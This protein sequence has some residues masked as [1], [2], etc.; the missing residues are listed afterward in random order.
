MYQL[1]SNDDQ[2]DE[3]IAD[4]GSDI[5]GVGLDTETYGKERIDRLFSLQLS[6]SRN[7]WYFN[8]HDYGGVPVLDK[9]RTFSALSGTLGNSNALWFIHN[10]KF[11]MWKLLLENIR[12]SG[13]VHCTQS[14]E[15]FIYN[16]YI[17][18]SL[19]ACL[20]RRGRQKND[21]VAAYID[22]HKLWTGTGDAKRKHF[23]KVPFPTM[24]R[25]ACIDAEEVRWLG[26]DQRRELAIRHEGTLPDYYLNDLEMQKV[27]FEMEVT[28]MHVRTDYA[29]GGLLYEKEQ[30]Q[31]TANT[32]SDLAGEPFRSGPNWL[33][34]IFD[35]HG[36]PYRTNPKTGNP[37][38]DKDALDE[39]DHPIAGLIRQYRR[40]EKYGGTY[41]DYYRTRE[42]IHAE[43]K[44]HGTD[45]G[46]FSYAEPNLQNVPKEE[47]LD[48]AIPFQVR[49]CFVPRSKDHCFVAIDFNQQEFRLMLDYAGEHAL[50]RRI[51]DHGEDVHQATADLVGVTRKQAKTINFGLLYGMGVEKLA[52]ALGITIREAKI[53]KAGYFSKLPK[54]QRLIEAIIKKAERAGYVETWVGRRLYVPSPWRDPDTRRLL[55]F[56][57]V[58]PNHLIQGGCGDIARGAMPPIANLLKAEAQ[59]SSMLLQVHDELLF[60]VHKSEL[61]VVERIVRIMENT[62]KPFNGMKMTC[63]VDHSWVSW[64]KRDVIA[65]LPQ[66]IPA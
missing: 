9:T 25:Y 59:R 51:N 14:V 33:R 37:V 53:L 28:G 52:A 3:A 26:L 47:T 17:K 45:T 63:G 29:Q 65:G 15:R 31:S 61:G 44:L 19:A 1:V 34:G 7:V 5:E 66:L 24:F 42:L 46:R 21:A 64:G 12:L 41:Y 23:E 54:V 36:V 20:E 22:E 56:E 10:A 18:Y 57:Y 16:Q 38:F 27:A 49:G 8:F 40:H 55:R 48:A 13:G 60:D 30:Q 32:L 43:I 4:I 50:I 39:I 6:T 35:K 11:D 2:L 58:M 62:Y